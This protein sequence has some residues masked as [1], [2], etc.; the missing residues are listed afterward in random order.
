[1]AKIGELGEKIVGQWLE[2]KGYLI[3][4]YRW[5][6]QW[7]EIDIIAQNKVDLMLI[8]VEVKTRS[9]NN[10]DEDGLLAITPKKQEKIRLTA[11]IFLAKNP[12]LAELPCRFDVAILNYKIN[13]KTELTNK[14]QKYFSLEGYEFTLINYLEAAF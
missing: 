3:L 4:H 13:S 14:L 2:N 10:W 6:C 1:M 11:E 9:K 7:G 12:S 5:R 8:F